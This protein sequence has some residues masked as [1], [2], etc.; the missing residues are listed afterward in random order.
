LFAFSD[1]AVSGK[2][3]TG[4]FSGYYIYSCEGQKS[5]DFSCLFRALAHQLN[6]PFSDAEQIRQELLQHL[7]EYSSFSPELVSLIVCYCQLF[8]IV[9][10]GLQ[11]DTH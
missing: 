2:Q 1:N 5:G 11:T 4:V 10:I 8:L 9:L 6:R 7:E 3:G